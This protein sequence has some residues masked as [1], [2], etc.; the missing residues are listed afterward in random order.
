MKVWELGT[1]LSAAHLI[2]LGPRALLCMRCGPCCCL[3]SLLPLAQAQKTPT[4][5]LPLALL[6]QGCSAASQMLP[7]HLAQCLP[8]TWALQLAR[9]PPFPAPLASQW[10]Q[11]APRLLGILPFRGCQ[12]ERRVAGTDVEGVEP[13]AC[14]HR[15]RSQGPGTYCKQV[16]VLPCNAIQFHVE[17]GA[18]TWEAGKPGFGPVLHSLVTRHNLWKPQF[19]DALSG[20]S[21]A[22]HGFLV[23]EGEIKEV[24]TRVNVFGGAQNIETKAK[25][26]HTPPLLCPV[27]KADAANRVSTFSSSYMDTSEALSQVV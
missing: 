15:L 4:W 2:S 21:R 10:V 13:R 3:G 16:Q 25:M 23:G 6:L 20:D 26:W 12:A 22:S 17:E 24:L 1:L 5:A 27:P 19:P 11:E 7:V 9:V 14:G 8:V 18:Q